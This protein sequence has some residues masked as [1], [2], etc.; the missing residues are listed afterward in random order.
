M[1]D[2]A[3]ESVAPHVAIC[4]IDRPQQ[5]NALT[6]DLM[7]SLADQLEQ[8]DRDP[9]VRCIIVAGTA[10]VFASGADAGGPPGLERGTYEEAAEFW[11]RLGGLETPMIAAVSGWALGSGCELALACDMC[12]AAKGTQFGQPEVTLGMI[13]GGGATQRLTRVIGKQRTMSLVL[14]GRRWSAEQG[15]EWGLVNSLTPPT[16]WL[17]EATDLA[18]EVAARA[19]IATRIGKRAVL[20]ADQ[21]PLD[22]GLETERELCK[23]T[24]VS[25]DRIEGVNALAEGRRPEFQGR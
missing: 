21:L 18:R 25:E 8:L 15:R 19:P 16:T 5:R 17:E 20:A 14:T 13:P 22:Q 6:S 1:P 7:A 2:V 12:V 24:L 10:K 3:S 11:S 9:E 23:Q 4:R